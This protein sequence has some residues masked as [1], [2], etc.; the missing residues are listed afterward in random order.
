MAPKKTKKVQKPQPEIADSS[1]SKKQ[2]RAL[3][4]QARKQTDPFEQFVDGLSSGAGEVLNYFGRAAQTRPQ[5]WFVL[6][7]PDF[8]KPTLS[9]F[10]TW[11]E[12]RTRVSELDGQATQVYVFNG[13]RALL[14]KSRPRSI[15]HPN[16]TVFRLQPPDEEIVIDEAGRMSND[17]LEEED[18][19]EELIY[20]PDDDDDE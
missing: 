16:G 17:A 8:G 9:T 6:E 4:L 19:E 10:N 3:R 1:P 11:A 20:E 5:Q 13:Y 12:T 2:R 7:V 15:I 18:E 14:T